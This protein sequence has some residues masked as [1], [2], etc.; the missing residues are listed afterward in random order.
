MLYSNGVVGRREL[1][2]LWPNFDQVMLRN[3]GGQIFGRKCCK[4]SSGHK[5]ETHTLHL[6]SELNWTVVLKFVTFQTKHWV[7]TR[8]KLE[9]RP[10]TKN[11]RISKAAEKKSFWGQLVFEFLDISAPICYILICANFIN[12]KL[13]ASTSLITKFVQL[14]VGFVALTVYTEQL[15]VNGEEPIVLVMHAR[16]AVSQLMQQ[17]CR[18]GKG[19]FLF[20]Y[21]WATSA[22]R[23]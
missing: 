16:H 12:S 4:G 19:M 11:D 8:S 18:G 5:L 21:S 15:L 10:N 7:E 9:K 13:T 3:A 20:F 6:Q 17:T 1:L 23:E 22:T 2:F 14:Y